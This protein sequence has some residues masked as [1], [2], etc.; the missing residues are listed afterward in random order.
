MPGQ[1]VATHSTF[2]L[3]T[4][5][6]DGR[7]TMGAIATFLHQIVT[8]II[9]FGP[10]SSADGVPMLLRPHQCRF[11]DTAT[12]VAMLLQQTPALLLSKVI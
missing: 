9:P 12:D 3:L 10:P 6:A 5:S 7:R 11:G 2:N 4:P 1:A 8:Q